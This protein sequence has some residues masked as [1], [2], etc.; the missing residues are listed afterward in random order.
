MYV[1]L[2][3]NRRISI[4]VHN[5]NAFKDRRDV[6]IQ[7]SINDKEIEIEALRT[8]IKGIDERVKRINDLYIDM[9]KDRSIEM[10]IYTTEMN[11]YTFL[12]KGIA[13][14]FKL[15]QIVKNKEVDIT[16]KF[17]DYKRKYITYIK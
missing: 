5:F 14:G 12:V 7:E 6:Q 3:Y 10:N 16:G 2:I 9:S 17:H 8:K 15:L 4:H 1:Y 13:R 11:K